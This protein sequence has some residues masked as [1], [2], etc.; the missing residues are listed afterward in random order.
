MKSLAKRMI[1]LYRNLSNPVKASIWFTICN[2]LQKGISLLTTPIFTRILTTEQY[3]TFSVYQSWY[4]ILSILGTLNLYSSV[5]NNGM[6][7]YTKDRKRF[8]SSMLGLST[9]C[10]S[11]LFLVYLVNVE[12][13]NSLFGLSTVFMVA[14]FAE[15]VFTPAFSFW[16]AEE[17][18]E[19]RYR[20]LVVYTLVLA[21]LCPVVSVVC[22]MATEYKAEAR[23]VGMVMVQCVF[24]LFFYIYIFAKG[25]KFCI[26]GYWKFAL[27]FNVPLIPHYL[28]MVVL[29]QADRIMIAQMVGNNKAA[30]YS[31]AY[32]IS[33]LMT[34]VTNG[35]N[36]SYT[37]YAYQAIQEKKY[38]KLGK[39]GMGLL[40]FVGVS[41]FA[42]MALAP[43]LIKIFATEEYYEA[44]WII[45]PIAASVYFIFFYSIFTAVEFY[46]EKTVFVMLA[47]VFG[48]VINVVLN[49]FGIKMFGYLA[50]GY[51]TLICYMF[52]G[53]AHYLFS[54]RVLIKK[55]GYNFFSTRNLVLL[56]CAVIIGML[57]ITMIYPFTWLRY[58]FLFGLIL[59]FV[60]FR[61]KILNI[62]SEMREMKQNKDA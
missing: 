53:V 34:L 6:L 59:L 12:F 43:E 45:P 38:E 2:I 10:C 49:F 31:I 46:Y 22:V 48:A 13:W 21:L 52:F 7:K 32:N 42:T 36:S 60:F 35:I 57:F 41:I 23:V 19:F 51:T 25:K 16:S 27:R 39:V 37:P 3:G 24:S 17:R 4:A 62:V 44:V 33:M 47:S 29:Q 55:I 30:I 26:K 5:F 20:K 9:A 28:S 50:A 15:M 14:M 54:S 56:S 1:G 8:T 61:E 11:I 40:V 58:V 18:F